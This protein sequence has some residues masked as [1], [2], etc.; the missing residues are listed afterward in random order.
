MLDEQLCIHVKIDRM[1]TSKTQGSHFPICKSRQSMD[2]PC[3][4][5]RTHRIGEDALGEGVVSAIGLSVRLATGFSALPEAEPMIDGSSAG[6]MFS[7]HIG[8]GAVQGCRI[9][10]LESFSKKPRPP[11]A[12]S[13]KKTSARHQIHEARA[14]FPRAP[15]A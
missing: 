9:S 4:T 15:L 13:Q 11:F 5:R 2:A 6:N 3:I 12:N 1:I 14:H 10:G 8:P 7:V